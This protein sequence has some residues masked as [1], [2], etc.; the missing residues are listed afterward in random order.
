VDRADHVGQGKRAFADIE[1]GKL[2]PELVRT[3][4]FANGVVI[5]TDRPR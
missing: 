1:A 5:L 3:H 4:R 2:N